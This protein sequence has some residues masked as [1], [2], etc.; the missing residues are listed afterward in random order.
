M[1]ATNS[2][3]EW[4][5][6]GDSWRRLNQAKIGYECLTFVFPVKTV[7][8]YST[9]VPVWRN[10]STIKR[11]LGVWN[12]VCLRMSTLKW[13]QIRWCKPHKSKDYIYLSTLCLR[14]LGYSCMDRRSTIQL[15]WW[16]HIST[17]THTVLSRRPL[18]E[19]HRRRGPVCKPCHVKRRAGQRKMRGVKRRKQLVRSQEDINLRGETGWQE[20]PSNKAWYYCRKGVCMC[21]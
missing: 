15:T 9:S 5:S 12:Y 3:I 10:G 8:W 18:L 2:S 16:T 7:L 20:R 19:P 21:V 13:V 6:D 1:L 11:K 4:L 17:R 14:S